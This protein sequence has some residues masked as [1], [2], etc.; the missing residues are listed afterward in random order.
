LLTGDAAANIRAMPW[1]PADTAEKQPDAVVLENVNWI[2]GTERSW[3]AVS[4]TGT[5]VSV[6]GNPENRHLAWIDRHGQ[7][8]QLSGEPDQITHA[9]LSRDGR[10]VVY[11]GRDSQWVRDLV[12]GTKT[13]I[14]SDLKTWTGGWLPGDDRIVISSNK[15]GNW[16]LYTIRA[17][18][19]DLTPLLTRPHTQHPLAVAPDGSIVFLDNSTTTGN[20]L[21]ALAPD[22]K[23]SP[24]VV[25]PFHESSANVSADGRYLAYVSD[26][27]GRN[28]VYAAPFSGQGDRVMV[29]VDGGTG[30][31]WSRDGRELFYRAGDDL[32]SVQVRST[33][34]LV[35]GERRK[36]VDVSAFEGMYFHDF[37]VSADGQRFLF[38]RAEP[39]A[40]PTRIDVIVNW[41]PEL[42]RLAG[43]K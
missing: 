40:R 4:A 19:G 25:T 34:P 2:P 38:I 29:S 26:E 16:D 32:M 10:R 6:P 39:G 28:D 5:A 30:P 11:N 15:T 14:V 43:G 17:S 8:T 33:T 35:L 41:L 12:T 27:S 7:V 9:T 22:G 23:L 36:L 13:R 31:V 1:R 20:D 21:W 37:D 3:I 24:L 18:G 42:A